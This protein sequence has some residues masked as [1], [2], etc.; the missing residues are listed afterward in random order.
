MVDEG[1]TSTFGMFGFVLEVLESKPEGQED[2]E[3]VV[4]SL[5]NVVGRG[6]KLGMRSQRSSNIGSGRSSSC[7][8]NRSHSLG[9]YRSSTVRGH[10]RSHRL[11]NCWSGTRSIYRQEL[12]S[13]RH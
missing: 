3:D 2:L 4:D 5:L 1:N 9:N 8:H 10:S 6:D 13:K 7:R 11:R 12:C